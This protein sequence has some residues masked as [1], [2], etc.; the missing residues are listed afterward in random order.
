MQD[1]GRSGC[2]RSNAEFQSGMVI[3]LVEEAAGSKAL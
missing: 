1:G 3:S 2:A